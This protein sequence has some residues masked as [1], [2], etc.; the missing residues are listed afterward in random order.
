[1]KRLIFSFLFIYTI[2]FGQSTLQTDS[3]AN[4]VLSI[5]PKKSGLFQKRNLDLIKSQ[6]ISNSSSIFWV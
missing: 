2:G 5:K 3:N 1:M 4:D 6:V